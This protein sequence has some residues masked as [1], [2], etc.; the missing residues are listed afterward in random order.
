MFLAIMANI[1]RPIYF[2][3]ANNDCANNGSDYKVRG[4]VKSAWISPVCLFQRAFCYLKLR[5]LTCLV[6]GR[7]DSLE[8]VTA[9]Y[10]FPKDEADTS[11]AAELRLLCLG[12]SLFRCERFNLTE[13]IFLA[14]TSTTVSS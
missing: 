10:V 5:R 1:I 7:S 12:F 3:N 13:M 4:D 9:P 14:E 8:R 11:R 2:S 6:V